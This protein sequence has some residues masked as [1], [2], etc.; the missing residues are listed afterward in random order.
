M[1]PTLS[2]K[3]RF[4]KSMLLN[5]AEFYP[6]Y[7]INFIRQYENSNNI[8]LLRCYVASN[9]AVGIGFYETLLRL[10][11]AVKLIVKLGVQ[12]LRKYVLVS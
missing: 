4:N 9:N 10:V 8:I 1:N 11:V 2:F 12:Y 6:V 3:V 5:A 7:Y